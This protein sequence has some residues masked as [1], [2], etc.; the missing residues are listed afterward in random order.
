MDVNE[1]NILWSE[2]RRHH[3]LLIGQIPI[4]QPKEAVDMPL[5]S[6]LMATNYTLPQTVGKQLV[7]KRYIPT[8]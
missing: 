6:A 3:H 8:Y 5:Y 4:C 1:F 2:K 7:A